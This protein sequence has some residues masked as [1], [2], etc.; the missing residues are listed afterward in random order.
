MKDRVR[1]YFAEKIDQALK[2]KQVVNARYSLRAFARSLNIQPAILSDVIRGKR[3]LPEKTAIEIA[4]KLNLEG[5]EK[6]SF[7][8]SNLTAKSSIWKSV[9]TP[10]S[11]YYNLNENL[12]RRLIEEWQHS[13]IFTLFE[14]DGF[15]EN[16]AWWEDN[17]GFSYEKVLE[18]LKLLESL[19]FLERDP[20]TGHFVKVVKA[21]RST[22]DLASPSLKNYHKNILNLASKKIDELDVD[23]RFFGASSFAMSK[24]RLSEAKEL[25]RNFK[26]EF[27]KLMQKGPKDTVYQINIQFF[28]L[29][30]EK[31]EGEEEN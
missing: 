15:Q 30:D 9:S 29:S 28:P 23:K 21:V 8:A 26:R 27:V 16:K 14:L 24:E 11:S 22:K 7:L 3:T 5:K 2:N 20:D 6:D 17:T 10:T 18:S 13:Y 1:P 4:D 12:M 19:G 25:I 31:I